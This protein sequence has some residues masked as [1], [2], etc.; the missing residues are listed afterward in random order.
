[1]KIFLITSHIFFYKKSGEL[2]GDNQESHNLSTSMINIICHVLSLKLRVVALSGQASALV[3][4]LLN[5]YVIALSD[6]FM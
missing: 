4:Y 6:E 3:A 5:F 1:V 2:Y